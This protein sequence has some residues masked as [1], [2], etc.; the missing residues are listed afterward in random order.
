MAVFDTLAASY[1]AVFAATRLGRYLRGRVWAIVG[2]MCT[3]GQRVL[4]VGCGTGEDAI[5]LA[6]LGLTVVA[7]EVLRH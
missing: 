2:P 1:D 3:P 5:W 6:R 4:D 7:T